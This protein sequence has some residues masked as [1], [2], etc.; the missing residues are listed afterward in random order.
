MLQLLH[1][2]SKLEQKQMFSLLGYL[3]GFASI[4]MPQYVFEYKVTKLLAITVYFGICE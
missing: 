3:L 2:M 1:M 4:Q